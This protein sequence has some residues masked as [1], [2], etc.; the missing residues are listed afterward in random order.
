MSK[1]NKTGGSFGLWVS[2][3]RLVLQIIDMLND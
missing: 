2:L 1:K 3:S